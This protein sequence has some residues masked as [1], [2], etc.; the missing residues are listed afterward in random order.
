MYVC[1]GGCQ[2]ERFAQG[3]VSEKLKKIKFSFMRNQVMKFLLDFQIDFIFFTFF[4]QRKKR[5]LFQVGKKLPIF[6]SIKI[7]FCINLFEV[8]K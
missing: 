1:Y 2:V 5:G 3:D 6:F 8:I 4:V 7:F